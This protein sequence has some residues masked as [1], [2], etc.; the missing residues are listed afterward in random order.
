MKT[1]MHS[2]THFDRNPCIS[3]EI[4]MEQRSFDKWKIIW[5]TFFLPH[6][7]VTQVT[8]LLSWLNK[9]MNIP[10]LLW[11]MYIFWLVVFFV[12]I[13]TP[14]TKLCSFIPIEWWFSERECLKSKESDVVQQVGQCVRILNYISNLALEPGPV[15]DA[16][17]KLLTHQY[18]SLTMLTKYFIFRSTKKNPSFQAVRYGIFSQVFLNR[19]KS[20]GIWSHDTQCMWW[21]EGSVGCLSSLA[22]K[23]FKCFH[24]SWFEHYATWGHLSL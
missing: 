4:C 5:N 24:N 14:V 1:C 6:T 2:C 3:H 13:G 9:W 22:S 12:F 11:Y 7:H 19:G 20:I 23:P 15:T 10:E 8:Q 18:A 21:E 16:V 17:L